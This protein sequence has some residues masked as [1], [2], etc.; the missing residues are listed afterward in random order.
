M[1][2]AQPLDEIADIGRPGRVQDQEQ[3]RCRYVLKKR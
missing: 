2:A 3:G 1:I